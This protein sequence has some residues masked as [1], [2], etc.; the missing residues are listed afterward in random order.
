MIRIAATLVVLAGCTD[1]SVHVSVVVASAPRDYAPHLETLA[2]SVLAT[3]EAGVDCEAI[4]YGE[5]DREALALAE[6][7]G[8]TLLRGD[9]VADVPI[10]GVPR[11]G[12]KLWLAEGRRADDGLAVIAGCAEQGD[13]EDDAEVTIVTEAVAQVTLAPHQAD[14]PVPASLHVAV[15]DGLDDPEPLADRPVRWTIYGSGIAPIVGDPTTTGDDGT[16]E[17]ALAPPDVFGPASIQ[18]R[19]RW[20]RDLPELTTAFEGVPA[21]SLSI[22]RTC[23]GS[24]ADT[25]AVDSASWSQFRLADRLAIAGLARDATRTRLY[26]ASWDGAAAADVCSADL[27]GVTTFTILRSETTDPV[28]RLLVATPTLWVE[29]E[30]DVAGDALTLTPRATTAWDNPGATAPVAL[31]TMRACRREV[32][33]D[34]YVLAQLDDDTVIALDRDGHAVDEPFAAK[35]S[36]ALPGLGNGPLRPRIV[37][38]G[39]IAQHEDGAPPLRAVIVAFV[40]TSDIAPGVLPRLLAIDDPQ[41]HFTS[42]MVPSIGA[43]AFTPVELDDPLLLGGAI[44]PTGAKVVRWKLTPGDDGLELREEA[45]DDSL[46]PPASI[47]YGF[48]DGD[49]EPDTV[50]GLVDAVQGGVTES[51]LQMSMGSRAGDVAL[52]SVTEQVDSPGA[53]VFLAPSSSTKADLVVGGERFTVFLDTDL[54]VTR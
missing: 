12:H 5:V 33:D 36:A 37:K 42:V 24:L 25:L 3:E 14:A 15:D 40:R 51:R 22:N 13:I 6:V 39:C 32:G 45:R 4:A 30:V 41:D 19:A 26:V 46:G 31:V 20:A 49:D 16:V 8:V 21:A 43:T 9:D 18:V 38:S 11:L 35:L 10:T 1:P 53:V 44:D 50:W 29:T 48:L 28:D 47:A 17:L 23:T 34:D 54:A 2:I 7:T 52:N 27:P